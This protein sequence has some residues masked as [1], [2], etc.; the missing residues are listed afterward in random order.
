MKVCVVYYKDHFSSAASLEERKCVA[1]CIG[2]E[3]NCS[4]SDYRKFV[5]IYADLGNPLADYEYHQILKMAIINVEEFEINFFKE[6][7][8]SE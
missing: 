2:I 4:D 7:E 1:C 8:A 6:M 5:H 3:V